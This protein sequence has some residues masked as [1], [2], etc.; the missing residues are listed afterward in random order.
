MA[1]NQIKT[2]NGDEK[3]CLF[4]NKQLIW[5]STSIT[6]DN[7]NDVLA[8]YWPFFSTY[9]LPHISIDLTVCISIVFSV[10]NIL[11][12]LIT[13]LHVVSLWSRVCFVAII[14]FI[15]YVILDCLYQRGFDIQ[16]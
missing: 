3:W 13:I 6:L 12:H 15:A 1:K 10:L 2:Q 4:I 7:N 14:C 8:Y 11:T 16:E 9:T 5:W